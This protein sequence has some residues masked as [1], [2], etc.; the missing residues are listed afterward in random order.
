MELPLND[1]LVQEQQSSECLVL[2]RRA[3]AP[4]DRQRAQEALDVRFGKVCGMT[5]VVKENEPTYPMDVRFFGSRAVVTRAK[6]GPHAIEQ[7]WRAGGRDSAGFAARRT[8]QRD[9][10]ATG[11][12]AARR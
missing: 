8:W 3:H 11:G 5:L 2:R 10:L 9:D 12:G 7:S 1:I 6:N 4:L